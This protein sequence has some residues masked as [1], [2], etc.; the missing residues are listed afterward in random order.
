MTT[1]LVP[2]VSHLLLDV[3][4]VPPFSPKLVWVRQSKTSDTS[5][6][7]SCVKVKYEVKVQAFR[8]CTHG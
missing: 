5:I 1:V 8:F 4:I 3:S 6:F 7:M 2:V